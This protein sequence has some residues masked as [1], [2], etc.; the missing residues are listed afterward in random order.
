MGRIYP[1]EA[2]KIPSR[3]SIGQLTITGLGR[4]SKSNANATIENAHTHVQKA[5]REGEIA[6]AIKSERVLSSSIFSRSMY[7]NGNYRLHT[8]ISRRI[9][10]L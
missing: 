6:E 5:R 10:W 7:D 9:Q 8:C 4:V 1:A 3:D 2:A